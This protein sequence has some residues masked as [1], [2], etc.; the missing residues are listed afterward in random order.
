[1]QLAAAL[2]VCLI[3]PNL[4]E[5]DFGHEGITTV[6]NKWD[7]QQWDCLCFGIFLLANFS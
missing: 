4:A 5:W 1:M 3:K 2:S 6:N 7:L